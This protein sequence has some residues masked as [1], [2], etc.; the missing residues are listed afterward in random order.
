MKMT[1]QPKKRTESESSWLQSQNE[2]RRRKK[3]SGC[4]KS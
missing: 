2:Q 1:F 4:K 3:S